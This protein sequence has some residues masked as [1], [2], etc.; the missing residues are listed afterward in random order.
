MEELND[1]GT[2]HSPIHGFAFDGYPIFGPYQAL[3]QLAVPCWKKRDYSASSATGCGTA[4]KRTCLLKNQWD[5]SQGTVSATSAGPDTTATVSSLS[6]NSIPAVSGVYFEDYYYDSTCYAQGG[7]YLDQ[8]NGHDHDGIG[9]HYH[10]T[11]DS[12][13]NPIFPYILGPQFYGC[14]PSSSYKC[15]LSVAANYLGTTTYGTSVCDSTSSAVGATCTSTSFNMTSSTVSKAPTTKPTTAAPSVAPTMKPT[16]APS[17]AAPSA[18]PTSAAPVVPPTAA[19]T[20]KPST[21]KPSLAPT[22][23]PTAQV[24][25]IMSFTNELT[26]VGVG[27]TTLS[28]DDKN[29][30]IE[31]IAGIMNVDSSDVSIDMVTTLR[32]L[33]IRQQS[34]SISLKVIISVLLNLVDYSTVSDASAFY[35]SL[36]QKLETAATDGTLTTSIKTLATAYGASDLTLMTSSSV[37]VNSVVIDEPDSSSGSKSD[38]GLTSN[39]MIGIIV[40]VVGGCILIALLAAAYV[41]GCSKSTSGV[42]PK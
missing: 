31:A 20:A 36:K 28:T 35:T 38:S 8:Y 23:T 17:F 2:D 4:N 26:L 12:S 6:S 7:Q 21:T 9:Y 22:V 3:N 42:A 14:L 25:P 18:T 11:M 41:Y 34:T 5:I 27:A 10:L 13:K 16:A 29:V 15:A 1:V 37:I 24:A 19:P 33:T 30:I 39:D 32:R 40:G